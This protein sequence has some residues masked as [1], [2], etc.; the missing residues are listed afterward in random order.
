[1]V[2]R[3]ALSTAGPEQDANVMEE[4]VEIVLGLAGMEFI[5][6]CHVLC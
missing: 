6:W 4:G 1:M 5:V 2:D 3:N